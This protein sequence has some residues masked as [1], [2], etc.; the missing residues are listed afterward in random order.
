MLIEIDRLNFE[1]NRIV[2]LTFSYIVIAITDGMVG[3]LRDAMSC[4]QEPVIFEGFNLLRFGIFGFRF[5]L[6]VQIPSYLKL[7]NITPH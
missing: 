2:H 4:D 1:R 5:A 7:G 6:T 3:T